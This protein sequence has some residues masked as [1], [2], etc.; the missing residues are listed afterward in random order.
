MNMSRHD[1]FCYVDGEMKTLVRIKQ[2]STVRNYKTALNALERY[3]GRRSLPFSHITRQLIQDFE[4]WLWHCG[5]CRNTSSAYLRSLQSLFNRAVDKHLVREHNPFRRVFT[6][7]EK[8]EKRGLR[9]SELRLLLHTD[10]GSDSRLRQARDV[11]CFSLAVC[12]MP[13]VDVAHLQWSQ[14]EGGRL[15][16]RR[17]KTGSRLSIRLEAEALSILKRYGYERDG[18]NSDGFIFPLLHADANDDNVY[19][20][21]LAAY[22]RR[23]QRIGQR[24]GLKRRL[25]SYV[26][27]HTWASLAQLHDMPVAVTQKGLGHTSLRTTA[28]YLA[29][30]ADDRLDCCNRR[31]L[32]TIFEKNTE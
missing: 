22:N 25:T 23:L 6:G 20:N 13:F 29:D 14:I 27:R 28:F 1:F 30:M 19:R 5:L 2:S 3:L 17:R 18:N 32:H 31:L 21:T 24:A 15:V 26:V 16:Y 11:F 4:Q 8:T 12:G 7:N 9:T 10:I